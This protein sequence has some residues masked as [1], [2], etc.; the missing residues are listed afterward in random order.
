MLS[1]LTQD[2][3]ILSE[4]PAATLSALNA[5]LQDEDSA[6]RTSPT[7]GAVDAA[8]GMSF[9]FTCPIGL[10]RPTGAPDCLPCAGNSIP[11]L[12]D[13][14]R[15][16]DCPARQAPDPTTA[17]TTCVCDSG[18]YNATLSNVECYDLGSRFRA[19]LPRSIDA[20]VPCEGLSCIV[21][22]LGQ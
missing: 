3:V 7:M 6:L 12:N 15:C 13:N 4:D 9:S 22:G 18:F 11:D 19:D 16:V 10:Y 8:A 20:C 21:C 17:L 5:Q 1:P 2:F 14:T